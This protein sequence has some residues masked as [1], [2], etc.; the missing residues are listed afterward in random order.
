MRWSS[1]VWAEQNAEAK[2]SSEGGRTALWVA[3]ILNPACLFDS[4]VGSV[5][6]CEENDGESRFV[7]QF[8]RIPRRFSHLPMWFIYNTA[9]V[10]TIKAAFVCE[11]RKRIQHLQGKDRAVFSITW[12]LTLSQSKFCYQIKNRACLSTYWR[13]FHISGSLSFKP[14]LTQ[15]MLL[16]AKN[17]TSMHLW[18]VCFAT[19]GV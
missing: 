6:S 8:H 14:I 11:K 4:A 9:H 3:L 16:I 18:P 2:A 10:R 5:S 15:I 7:P 12:N 17:R 13:R 1:E 19:A